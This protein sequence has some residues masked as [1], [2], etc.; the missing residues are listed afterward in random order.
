MEELENYEN[1]YEHSVITS[2]HPKKKYLLPIK[3]SKEIIVRSEEVNS[4][5]DEE[6]LQM[7]TNKKGEFFA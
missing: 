7:E 4:S 2:S 6:N 1:E 5:E 3:S